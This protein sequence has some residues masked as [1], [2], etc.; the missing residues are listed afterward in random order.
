[1]PRLNK[2]LTEAAPV[3]G[4]HYY[5]WDDQ[6]PGFGLRVLP[7]GNKTFIVQYRF[8]KRVQKLIIGRYPVFTADGARDEAIEILQEVRRGKNPKAK[9]IAPKDISTVEDLAK[10][11]LNE[12]CPSNQKPSTQGHSRL[13]VNKHIIPALGKLNVRA[14]TRADVTTLHYKMAPTPVAANHAL[15]ALSKM[16]NLAELWG[17]RDEGTNPCRGVKK[18]KGKKRE[19]Y[20][21]FEEA[22]ELGR[23]LQEHKHYP[24]Q[25]LAAIFCLQLLLL[26]GCR[27][28]ELLSL[29]WKSIDFGRQR[30]FL[31]DSKTGGR[32]IYLG[33]R[34]IDLLREIE[35]CPARPSD[36]IYVFWGKI[37]QRPLTDL[38]KTWIY[39]RKLVKIED[40]RIHDLRHSF[41]SFAINQNVSLATIGKL[42]GHTNV[43]TTTRYAHLMESTTTDA[44]ELVTNQIGDLLAM[45]KLETGNHDLTRPS[46]DQT[47]LITKTN[48]PMPQ[49]FTSD[50]A[51]LYLGLD[52]KSMKDW[53]YRKA[54]PSYDKIGNRIRYK[55]GDLDSFRRRLMI[56]A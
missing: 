42:L 52:P 10:R 49:Y 18:Y 47:Q 30:I 16:F 41:A 7:S 1:M 13:T 32:T 6:V 39:F 34:A 56:A 22:A 3:T 29:E 38:K 36:N 51:A 28:S 11:Y 44:A 12:Y 48:V 15:S 31:P 55:Q 46:T 2:K 25:N 40:V 54:G 19:R 4:K 37:P 45:P 21:T 26:T 27:K 35:A 20:L 23:A 5:V 9:R 17:L 53:R 50:Q 14:V 33:P 8:G 24:D 43:Q